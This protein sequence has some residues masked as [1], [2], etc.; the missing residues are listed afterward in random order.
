MGKSELKRVCR[1][2]KKKE[3]NVLDVPSELSM[4]PALLSYERKLGLR[5]YGRRGYDVIRDQ[6]FVEEQFSYEERGDQLSKTMTSWFSDFHDYKEFLGGDIYQNACYAFLPDGRIQRDDADMQRIMACKPFVDKTYTEDCKLSPNPAE[7]AVYAEGETIHKQCQRWIKIFHKCKTYRM[8][9]RTVNRYLR[10]DL[11]VD[12]NLEFFISQYLFFDTTDKQRLFIVIRFL[13]SDIGYKYA[14]LLPALCRMYG[15][16]DVLS[17]MKDH[18]QRLHKTMKMLISDVKNTLCTGKITKEDL[19]EHTTTFSV[20]VDKLLREDDLVLEEMDERLQDVERYIKLL[21]SGN[22]E[23]QNKG[24]FDSKTHYFGV[25]IK[26]YDPEDNLLTEGTR[27][28]NTFDDF[29]SYWGT[30]L[31]K[32]DFSAAIR[33]D[34]DLSGYKLTKTTKLP[35]QLEPNAVYHIKKQYRDEKFFVDQWWTNSFGSVIKGYRHIFN[36]FFD[37]AAFLK[38]DLSGADLLFL[39]GLERITPG[40]LKLEQSTLQSAICDRFQ[41]AYQPFWLGTE[42]ARTFPITEQNESRLGLTL[43]MPE[44][45][46]YLPTGGQK[47]FYISDLHLNH[48]IQ[49][50]NCRS[51]QDMLYIVTGTAREIARQVETDGLLLIAGDTASNIKVF[52]MFV[53]ALSENLPKSIQTIFT[54][55]NHELWGFP[56]MPIDRIVSVYRRLL[57]KYGMYLLHNDL[58]YKKDDTSRLMHIGWENLMK[59]DTDKLDA[60]LQNTRYVLFGGLGFSGYNETFNA[61]DQIYGEVCDRET[62]IRE[63]KK[64]ELIYHRIYPFLKRKNAIVVTH[65]PK[66]DW[67]EGTGWDDGLIYINGHTHRSF[68]SDDGLSKVYA[69]GQAGYYWKQLTVKAFQLDDQYDCFATYTDGIYEVEKQD[70]VDFYY[71][72]NMSM[73]CPVQEGKFYMLKKHGYYCFLHRLENGSLGILNGGSRRRL[74]NQDISYYYNAM[75]QMVSVVKQSSDQHAKLKSDVSGIIKAIGGTGLIHENTVDM[76]EYGSIQVNPTD[77][78]LSGYWSDSLLNK[79]YYPS[80]MAFLKT[81]YPKSYTK[82]RKLYGNHG[83]FVERQME[84]NTTHTEI[85][86]TGRLPKLDRTTRLDSK[87]LSFWDETEMEER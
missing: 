75:D 77:L 83:L 78:S 59:T 86:G 40:L 52:G 15:A 58:L 7:L 38:N 48:R 65:M 84:A 2:L 9:C 54:L 67:C 63:S 62:E 80:V 72:K 57:A 26:I 6:F 32:C 16:G 68:L 47:V 69:D 34:A 33:L 39:N 76:D 53:K 61:K 44:L 45:P 13:C 10:S 41:V 73:T 5:T 87:I 27:Y 60:C 56:N 42:W 8:F 64:T 31:S 74:T 23:F 14:N 70:Y 4:E 12:V 55:G 51:I 50:A 37:F 17:C 25:N 11:A 3:L 29:L 79:A 81:K 19:L 36:Y 46:F 85:L 1:Q 24:F 49:Q 22:L 18:Q 28:F 71:G 35:P 21:E 43:H 20:F 30:D 66:Q 82:Y